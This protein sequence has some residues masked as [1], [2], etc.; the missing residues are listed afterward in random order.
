[1][2][3]YNTKDTNGGKMDTKKII[4]W[5]VI[6]ILAVIVIY[7]TFISGPTG[8]ATNIPSSGGMIGGC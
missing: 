4:L 1:M 5:V 3:D 7:T 2:E 8:A 6:A